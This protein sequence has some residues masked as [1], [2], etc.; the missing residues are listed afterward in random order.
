RI[1]NTIV[2]LRERLLERGLLRRCLREK[3]QRRPELEVVRVTEHVS[4]RLPF[5]PVQDP[6]ALD[7]ASSEYR[8]LD[9]AASIVQRRDRI[10]PSQ[11]ALTAPLDL[12][13]DEPLPVIRLAAGE[14]LRPCTLEGLALGVDEAL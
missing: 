1:L 6:G 13:K 4:R 10:T 11:R 5:E 14:Q 8:V 9:V 7:Q 3:R 2:V 12:W